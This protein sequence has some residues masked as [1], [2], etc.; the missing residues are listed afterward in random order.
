ML[1]CRVVIDELRKVYRELDRLLDAAGHGAISRIQTAAGVGAS[2]LRDQRA[3]LAAGREQGYDFVG[4][5]R[6]LRALGVD[7]R[8]FFDRV[9]GSLEPIEVLKLETRQIG[10]PPQIVAEVRDLLRAEGWQPLPEV[11]RPIRDLDAHRYQDANEARVIAHGELVKVAAGLS[12]R[13]W[14]VPLLAVYGS[15]LRMTDD[16]DQAQQA[17]MAA[18]EIAESADDLST[19][20]DLLQRLAYVIADGADY[21][22]P[23]ELAERATECYLQS[24]DL[25]SVGK[26]FVDRGLWLYKL[27]HLEKA[28]RMQ[29]RALEHLKDDKYQ[30]RFTALQGLGLYHREIGEPQN[31]QEYAVRARELAPKLGA[32][33]VSNL[34]WLEAR[35]AVDLGEYEEAEGL[36]RETVSVFIPISTVAAA[37]ATTELVRVLLLQGR[38]DEAHATAKTMARFIDPLEDRSQIAAAVALDLVLCGQAGRGISLAL[39]DRVSETLEQERARPRGRARAKR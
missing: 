31:A 15:A 4:L 25:N 10:E 33:L 9:Y 2:Y 29:H 39:I 5:L 1:A 34:L 36:L 26:T 8:V 21:R 35:L 23:L 27:G 7:R 32:W 14:G 16:Y 12:P 20:G 17:L 28:I 6:I 24:G 18:L 13:S 3:R 11:P 37:L 22:R 19:L 30:N 38:P